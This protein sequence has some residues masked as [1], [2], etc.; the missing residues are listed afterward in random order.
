MQN[1]KISI[2]SLNNIIQKNASGQ[3]I[4]QPTDNIILMQKGFWGVSDDNLAKSLNWGNERF[5]I[6][7]ENLIYRH[8]KCGFSSKSTLSMQL[9]VTEE[10]VENMYKNAEI[11]DEGVKAI[12]QEVAILKNKVTLLQYQLQALQNQMQNLKQVPLQMSSSRQVSWD[13]PFQSNNA[14]SIP[15]APP[16]HEQPNINLTTSIP[17]TPD[18]KNNLRNPFIDPNTFNQLYGSP[19][20]TGVFTEKNYHDSNGEWTS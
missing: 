13:T 15:T 5:K 18:P 19:I 4:Q 20:T 14:P 10:N 11:R 16:L 1:K 12:P 9:G 7:L 3:Y 6:E 17:K 2:M 8:I